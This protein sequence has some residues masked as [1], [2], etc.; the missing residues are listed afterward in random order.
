[1]GEQGE[2]R[3]RRISQAEASFIVHGYILGPKTMVEERGKRTA[4]AMNNLTGQGLAYCFLAIN[5]S[6]ATII[7]VSK[8]TKLT[9]DP[10]IFLAHLGPAPSIG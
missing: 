7:G 2:A 8:T 3:A 4:N 1:M 10:S 9:P 6:F 5:Y